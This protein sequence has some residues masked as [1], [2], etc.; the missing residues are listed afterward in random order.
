MKCPTCGAPTSVVETRDV[1]RRRACAP[2]GKRF[3]TV[4]VLAGDDRE[5][6]ELVASALIRLRVMRPALADLLEDLNKLP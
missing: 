3:T 4:E 1:R 2:C 6:R 5:Q